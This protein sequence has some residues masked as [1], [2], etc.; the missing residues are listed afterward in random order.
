ME[1]YG[2]KLPDEHYALIKDK[3]HN[4][5]PFIKMETLQKLLPSGVKIYGEFFGGLRL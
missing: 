1:I 3:A 4:D 2:H 5:L